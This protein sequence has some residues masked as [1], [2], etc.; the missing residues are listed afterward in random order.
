MTQK[1]PKRNKGITTS[2]AQIDCVYIIDAT[3]EFPLGI[4][5]M[6]VIDQVHNSPQSK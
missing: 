3:A 1:L 2:L 4:N 5:P 6:G